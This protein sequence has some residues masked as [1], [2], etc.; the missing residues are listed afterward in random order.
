MNKVEKQILKN[1]IQ[2][3]SSI[4]AGSNGELR[5]NET[6]ELLNPTNNKE[7]CCDMSENYAFEE[8]SE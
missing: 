1:Q 8:K 2:I 3:L 4:C 6:Q 5:I 7:D